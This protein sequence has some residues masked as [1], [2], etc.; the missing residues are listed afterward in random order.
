MVRTI[1]TGGIP[2]HLGPAS[3]RPIARGGQPGNHAPAPAR[4]APGEPPPAHIVLARLVD[5]QTRQPLSGVKYEVADDQ[6]AAVARGTTDWTG[7]VRHGVQR[8]G[9]YQVKV[10]RE[11]RIARAAWST[12]KTK[13]GDEVEL[14]VELADP[15]LTPA[16]VRSV[17]VSA[18]HQEPVDV[19]AVVPTRAR[20]KVFEHDADGGHDPVGEPIEAPF[21][22]GKA[23][24]RFKVPPIDDSD[25]SPEVRDAAAREGVLAT[26][27]FEVEIDVEGAG[28]VDSGREAAKLLRVATLCL[29]IE[30]ELDPDQPEKWNDKIKLVADDGSF[31]KEL[32]LVAN[33]ERIPDKPDRRLVRFAN[34]PLGKTYTCTIDPGAEEGPPYTV[35]ASRLVA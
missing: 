27:F 23:T 33:G 6:G 13:I 8:A 22:G 4:D 31:E 29:D 9:Q 7:T 5:A 34:I 35:F 16:P 17:P 26:L 3:H 21:S 14:T 28:K 25:E 32:Q 20:L 1:S 10:P 12:L 19:P 24:A 30:V 18:A 11:A 15:P 2:P